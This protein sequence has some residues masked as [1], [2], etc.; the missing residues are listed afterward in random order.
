MKILV[1]G[2]AGFIGSHIVDRLLAAQHQVMGLD[3]FS[4]GRRENC[5]QALQNPNFS[6]HEGDVSN[7]ATLLDISQNIDAIYHEAALVSVPLS[8]ADP[9]ANFRNN[10]QGVFNI[11][12]AARQ[13]QIKRVIYASSAAVY[14]NNPHLPLTETADCQPLSPYALEKHYAEHTAKLYQRLYGINSVGLRYFNVFGP[15]QDPSSPYSG[16]ISIFMEKLSQQQPVTIFG[17]GKQTRDFIYIDDVVEANF[18]ALTADTGA[19]VLNVGNQGCISI[20]ELFNTLKNLLNSPIEAQYV[21]AKTGDIKHSQANNQHLRDV[22]AWQAKWTF[23]QGLA[24]YLKWQAT[25]TT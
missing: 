7:L 20:T 15:R 1:T 10:G 3:N 14:G 12:E 18:L 22:L 24:A 23:E 2:C 17:D 19:H 16:V 4:S 8:V 6:L 9:V 11:F 5:Q 25:Q 13:N 21:A